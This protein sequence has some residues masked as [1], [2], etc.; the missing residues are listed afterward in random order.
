MWCTI[1]YV[2]AY[3]TSSV[4]LDRYEEIFDE[5][6]TPWIH[7]EENNTGTEQLEGVGLLTGIKVDD[8]KI[9]I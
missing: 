2:P 7:T 5:V 9:K 6:V 1:Y 4:V 8:W 3:T